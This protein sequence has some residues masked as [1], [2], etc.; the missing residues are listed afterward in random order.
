MGPK[1]YSNYYGPYMSLK[2]GSFKG[3]SKGSFLS[4]LWR[5]FWGFREDFRA[6]RVHKRL[7][8]WNHVVVGA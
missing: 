7:R 6:K 5:G 1:P 4:G 3:S 8:L 2:V